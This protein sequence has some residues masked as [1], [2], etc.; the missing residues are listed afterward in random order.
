MKIER[1][2]FKMSINDIFRFFLILFIPMNVFIFVYTIIEGNVR[3]L[4]YDSSWILQILFP[5]VY[6][7]TNA[8][9]NRS[10][11]LK[12]TEISDYDLVKDKIETLVEQ[13]GLIKTVK[14]SGIVIFTKKSR[15]GRFFFSIFREDINIKYSDDEILIL[16]RRNSYS[17]IETKL[18]FDKKINQGQNNTR[19]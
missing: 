3:F 19:R 7:I 10:G 9:Y 15:L 8:A 14:D 6:A 13:R 1:Q 11:F 18:R 12:I 16:G 2:F 4:I 5:L 17:T